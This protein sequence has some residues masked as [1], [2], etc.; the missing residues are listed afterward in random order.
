MQQNH[1]II[2]SWIDKKGNEE[3]VYLL[4]GHSETPS[5]KKHVESHVALTGEAGSSTQEEEELS[6]PHGTSR[7]RKEKV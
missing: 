7:K 3:T 1:Y 6:P 2:S 4:A 5:K